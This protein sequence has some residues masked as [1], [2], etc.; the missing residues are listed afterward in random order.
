VLSTQVSYS[1]VPSQ[2]VVPALPSFPKAWVAA[3]DFSVACYFPEGNAN[4]AVLSVP[5]FEPASDVEFPD[6]IRQCLAT[7]NKKGKTK[8]IIDLR[9]NG[10]GTVLLA[11]DFFK[12]LFPSI[13]P[14]GT[15]NFRAFPLFND[16]GQ[17][18]TEYYESDNH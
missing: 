10:G 16:I 2:T 3:S 8:L 18:V 7:A 6:I 9:G 13:A 14:Y 17:T 4:L 11:Y 5:T 1:P 15:T 12:Q